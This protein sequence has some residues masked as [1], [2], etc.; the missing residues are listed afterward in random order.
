MGVA[1]R[2]RRVD[3]V[4]AGMTHNEPRTQETEVNRLRL[5]VLAARPEIDYSRDAWISLVDEF[6]L[7]IEREAVVAAQLESER[8]RVLATIIAAR[9]HYSKHDFGTNYAICPQAPCDEWRAALE[10]P[11][12]VPTQTPFRQVVDDLT[13]GCGCACHTGLGYDSSC[14]HCQGQDR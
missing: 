4:T 6:R 1:A 12:A 8:L 14:V 13:G 2:S 3:R 11:T 7:A 9:Y 10:S 5:I